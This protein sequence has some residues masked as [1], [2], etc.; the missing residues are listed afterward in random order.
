MNISNYHHTKRQSWC[1][2]PRD[3]STSLTNCY[4][5]LKLMCTTSLQKRE[6]ELGLSTPKLSHY[7]FSVEYS[8]ESLSL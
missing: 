4:I 7:K 5:S 3:M 2:D 6:H 8:Q 1:P